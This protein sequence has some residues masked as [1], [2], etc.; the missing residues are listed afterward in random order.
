[1]SAIDFTSFP[2]ISTDEFD[3]ATIDVTRFEDDCYVGHLTF[4]RTDEESVVRE[5]VIIDI[6]LHG[7]TLGEI[8][9]KIRVLDSIGFFDTVE[10]T[11]HGMLFDTEGDH[12]GTICWHTGGKITPVGEDPHADQD[13][14][15]GETPTVTV[16]L[17]KK[18]L[19]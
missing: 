11:Y 6:P 3:L 7:E 19:H 9:T 15:D 17:D 5:G 16:S 8:A 18:T 10:F 2:W 14:T 1:M 12:Q 4:L 13:D